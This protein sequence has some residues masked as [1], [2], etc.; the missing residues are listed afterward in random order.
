MQI[1]LFLSKII[2]GITKKLNFCL[3]IHFLSLHL[4]RELTKDFV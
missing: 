3:L 2:A 1:L 4:Y